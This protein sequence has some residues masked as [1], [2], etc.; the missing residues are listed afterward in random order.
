MRTTGVKLIAETAEYRRDMD[1]AAKSTDKVKDSI[2]DVSTASD[3]AGDAVK[4]LGGNLKDG[5]RGADEL[6]REIEQAERSLASLATQFSETNKAADRLDIARAI[7]KQQSELRQLLRVESL[8]PDGGETQNA[9]RSFGGRLFGGISAGLT[10]AASSAPGA[11]AG[12]VMGAALAPSIAAGIGAGISA[13]VG[14]GAIVAGIK[15]VSKDPQ[16]A[17]AGKDMGER[18]SRAVTL[19]AEAFKLPVLGAI[20]EIDGFLGQVAPKIGNIFRNVA[21]SVEGLTKNLTAAGNAIVDGLESA[22]GR[23]AGPLAALGEGVQVIGAE[24]GNMIDILSQRGPEGTSAINDLTNA[25]TNAIRVTTGLL[26]G[27]ARIKGYLD[28]MDSGVDKA[29]AW[30]EDHSAISKA[31]KDVGVNLDLTADGYKAGSAAA[32]LY[33]LGVI[34]AKGALNDYDHWLRQGL[35]ATTKLTAAT[36]AA[37]HPQKAFVGA[38]TAGDR[39]ARGE[40]SAMV[41]LSKEIRSQADPV[42]A[43]INAQDGLKKAQD[44]AAEATKKHGRNSEE[45]KA[46][47]RNLALAAL[48]LQAKAGALGG[49]FDGKLSPS[50]RNTLKAAGLTEAQIKDV[51]TQFRDAKRDGDKFAKN[52]KAL[53]TITGD[54]HVSQELARLN[55]IQQALRSGQPLTAGSIN[56]VMRQARM[57]GGGH[58]DGPG[59]ETSDDIPVMAS[60]NEYMVKAASAKKIGRRGM[61]YIN[62]YGELPALPLA[63]GGEVGWPFPTTAAKAWI[64]SQEWA[65]S[66]VT[67]PI[68]SWP[69]SPSAQRGDSG[70]WKSI[71]AL[72]K[73]SGIPYHFGNAYRPGD[74]KWH[75]SG[76]AID[77]MGYNQDRLAQFFLNRQSSVLELIHRTNKRD[78]GITRGHYNAMPTQ[79]PLHRNHL[80]VAMANGGRI[81]EPVFGVG[82]SGSTYSFGESGT[83]YVSN[84]PPFTMGTSASGGPQISTT[85]NLNVA[86]AAG[87]NPREAGRQI[88]EQLSSYLGGGGSMVVNGQKVLP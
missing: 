50:M 41:G 9:G 59:T 45:A 77:F 79:W 35:E 71:L 21:P 62:K 31:L 27:A 13:G 55:A 28:T 60:K 23:A 1:G 6:R 56:K 15:L 57:A 87:A 19:E 20:K 2:D 26:D 63:E 86:L 32:D 42:F 70:V 48:D 16:V 37:D 84:K 25:I 81:S 69:R 47:T 8:L 88:A 39:A 5:G 44:K 58:I 52:Y 80:H 73:G 11:V 36:Q 3:K 54:L 24:F 14:L 66:R 33:R 85:I 64:P 82:V 75:G 38:L 12:G 30:V 4:E 17:A 22:S 29:R 49:T 67:P 51:A 61:D 68:G 18:F 83:E 40:L 76:R 7:K 10:S 53:A 72:V 74:P 34:G 43:L 46:A 65:M 78:Y